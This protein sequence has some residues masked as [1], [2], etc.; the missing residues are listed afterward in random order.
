MATGSLLATIVAVNRGLNI[1][2]RWVIVVCVL[3]WLL[4][5]LII[6]VIQVLVKWLII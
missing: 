6:G 1:K 2:L 5:E 3:G 4:V